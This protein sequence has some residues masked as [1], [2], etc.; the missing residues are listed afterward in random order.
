MTNYVQTLEPQHFRDAQVKRNVLISTA[1]V[2]ALRCQGFISFQL[3]SCWDA[4]YNPETLKTNVAS[5]EEDLSLF[6][7]QGFTGIQWS[8]FQGKELGL[9]W[10]GL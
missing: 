4:P 9:E 7:T 6:I 10:N 3:H 1:A 5:E 8:L 2:L